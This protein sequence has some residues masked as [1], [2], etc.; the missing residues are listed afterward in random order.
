MANAIISNC[1]HC[2]DKPFIS[3]YWRIN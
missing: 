3:Q 1:F 2:V